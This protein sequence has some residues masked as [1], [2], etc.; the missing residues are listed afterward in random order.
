MTK[1]IIDISPPKDFSSAPKRDLK[2]STSKLPR[3]KLIFIFSIL[4]IGIV[5]IAIL[6]FFQSKLTLSLTPKTELVEYQQTLEVNTSQQAMDFQ[7]KIISGR[8]F[9]QE[10][11]KWA[12]FQSSGKDFEESK[13]KGVIRVYNTHDP[14]TPL[15]L[16][17]RTRFLSSEGGKI[18][19]TPEKIY[20]PPAK[21]E[22]GN[23]IPSYK[24][25][26]VIAQE[27]GEE[28]NIGPS[29]F[30]VPGLAGTAFY[31]TIW[32]ESEEKMKGGFRKEV[33]KI[34][35]DDLKKAEK[36]LHDSLRELLLSSLKDSL[37]SGFELKKEAT[38]EENFQIKCF[39]KPGDQLSEFNCQGRMRM[40]GIAFRLSD[41]EDFAIKFLSEK[42]PPRKELYRASLNLDPLVKSTIIEG[43]TGRVF[44]DLRIKGE[45]YQKIS[46]DLIVEKI[47]GESKDRIEELVSAVYPQI[48]EVKMEF[49]PFWVK[50]APKNIERINI[51]LTF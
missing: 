1:K 11:E 13:A 21:K 40:K 3:K 23:I 16:R 45:V 50:K 25:V 2:E 41:L 35:E 24:D 8:I 49:W 51:E 33:K 18:F 46:P 30:S 14:P 5:V 32:A 31:Y 29:K 10:K 43:E 39:A 27:A 47:K 38:V 48:K 15:T 6:T 34:T 19:R 26:E 4:A 36:K 42:L 9:T 28:Y 7:E 12:T 17:A 44:L 22:G 20:L 37:P